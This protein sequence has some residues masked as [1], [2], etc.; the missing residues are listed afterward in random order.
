MSCLPMCPGSMT[1]FFSVRGSLI[2][3]IGPSRMA[4]TSSLPWETPAD[5]LIKQSR[6]GGAVQAYGNSPFRMTDDNKIQILLRS[7][8]SCR[9][10]VG[11]RTKRDTALSLW[12]LRITPPENPS[13]RQGNKSIQACNVPPSTPLK[14]NTSCSAPSHTLRLGPSS[15]SFLC[16]NFSSQ[17]RV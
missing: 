17:L 1:R 7:P 11:A 4:S 16:M 15:M 13:P 3:T 2:T 5:V 8:C 10:K 12:P 9:A 14:T 6:G